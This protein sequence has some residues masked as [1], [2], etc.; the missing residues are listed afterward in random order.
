[1]T[2]FFHPANAYT[3]PTRSAT[4][5][6]TPISP[7]L[8]ASGH[9]PCGW[10]WP[11]SQSAENLHPIAPPGIPAN[12]PGY[13]IQRLALSQRHN[14]THARCFYRPWIASADAFGCFHRPEPVADGDGFAVYLPGRIKFEQGRYAHVFARAWFALCV[15][16]VGRKMLNRY[17][18]QLKFIHALTSRIMNNMAA[19]ITPANIF[20]PKCFIFMA[21]SLSG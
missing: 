14:L 21:I 18:A 6:N 11:L 19:I 8:Y 20:Q 1:M 4:Y 2:L 16:F 10:Y 7:G 3:Q 12:L 5:L 15:E 9:R 17:H 13:E